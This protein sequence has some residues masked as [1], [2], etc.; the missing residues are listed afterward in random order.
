MT[1][2]KSWLGWYDWSFIF[3]VYR[4]GDQVTFALG[5]ISI[6]VRWK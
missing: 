2:A 5:F 4:Y 6:M 3:G 1:I